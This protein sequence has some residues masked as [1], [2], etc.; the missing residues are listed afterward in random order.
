[1]DKKNAA[2]AGGDPPP[3]KSSSAAT[4]A[5]EPSESG[6]T[7]YLE[8]YLWSEIERKNSFLCCSSSGSCSWDISEGNKEKINALTPFCSVGEAILD[9]PNKLSFKKTTTQ[10]IFYD[11]SLEDT[12][13]SP[14][15]TPKVPFNSLFFISFLLYFSII[16]LN[17]SVLG[18]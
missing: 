18:C 11:D 3:E 13:T 2:A 10:T 16:S 4:G 9:A 17:F 14:V 15:L 5:E 1:M 8:D 7:E 6:W 12:A